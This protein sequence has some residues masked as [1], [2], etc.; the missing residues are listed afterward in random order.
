MCPQAFVEIQEQRF[1]VCICN[2]KPFKETLPK[3][4]YTYVEREYILQQ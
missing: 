1:I 3:K 4:K 2:S